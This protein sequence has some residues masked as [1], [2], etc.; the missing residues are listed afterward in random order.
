VILIVLCCSQVLPRFFSL[1]PDSRSG[2][3]TGVSMLLDDDDIDS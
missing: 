3:K 2:D 1:S